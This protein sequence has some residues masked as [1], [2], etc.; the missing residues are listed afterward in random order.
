[1]V[2]IGRRSNNRKQ[3]IV[4]AIRKRAESSEQRHQADDEAKVTDAIDNESFVGGVGGAFAFEIKP[5]QEI[6][7]NPDQLPEH[8]RHRQIARDH[9]AQ[10]AETEERQILEEPMKAAGAMKVMAVGQ[11]NF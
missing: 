2:A 7:A 5:N 1:M 3:A 6:R 8:E 4:S 10:H 11:C 9:E